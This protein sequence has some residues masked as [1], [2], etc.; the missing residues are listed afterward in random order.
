M[1]KVGGYPED[2]K[3]G[4][5]TLF[6]EKI[7]RPRLFKIQRIPDAIGYWEMRENLKE[8]KEQFF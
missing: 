8:V 5:D 4:E 6:N 2:L 3:I 1:E 7:K